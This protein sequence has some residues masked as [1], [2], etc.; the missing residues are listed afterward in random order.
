MDIFFDTHDDKIY[1]MRIE[2]LESLFEIFSI[3]F[4]YKY[5]KQYQFI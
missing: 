2:H 4:P 3:F 5:L 1:L